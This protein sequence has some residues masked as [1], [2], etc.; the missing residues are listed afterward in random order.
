MTHTILSNSRELRNELIDQ[1]AQRRFEMHLRSGVWVMGLAAVLLMGSIWRLGSLH[2]QTNSVLLWLS[3]YALCVFTALVSREWLVRYVLRSQARDRWHI[4]LALLHGVMWA[5]VPILFFAAQEPRISMMMVCVAAG[6]CALAIPMCGTRPALYALFTLPILITQVIIFTAH[7]LANQDSFHIFLALLAFLI[8]GASQWF[9]RLTYRTLY[10]SIFLSYE[11]QELVMQLRDQAHELAI[12]TSSAQKANLAKTKFLAA[13]SHD[14]RQPVHAL[15]LFIEVLRTTPLDQRQQMIVGNIRAASQASREL[16]SSLLDYSQIE[17]GVMTAKPESC[18]L[19]AILMRLQEEFGPQADAKNLVYRCRDSEAIAHCDSHMV[20]LVLR[21][22]IS[23]AIRYTAQGGVLVAV[24]ARGNEWGVQVWDTGIG[25]AKHE[26]EDIFKEFHQVGNPERD[27]QK[28]V[29]LGLAIAQ[30]L[31]KTMGTRVSVRSVVGR[32][33]VFTLWLPKAQAPIAATH[34]SLLAATP[35]LEPRVFPNTSVLIVDDMASVRDG[36]K[37]LLEHWGCQVRTAQTAQQA[38]ALASEALPDILICDYRLQNN[39]TGV[40][41]VAAIKALA[42]LNS[43]L[44]TIMITGDIEPQR[45]E[46]ATSLGATLLYKPISITALNK[47]VHDLAQ[48][49]L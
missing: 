11:N 45:L 16:L 8:I 49:S 42:P 26:Q 1:E 32:G 30:G 40:Q 44:G 10:E 28:G 43:M 29:G 12:Q 2:T 27:Q 38:I 31:A 20:A 17:A 14:L 23:N 6:L 35:A 36:M 37:L 9:S 13:A 48:I 3:A 21:N 15:N 18:S 33:S 4:A 39:N 22:F 41:V 34:E 5:F 47:A 25:I 7:A 46:E 24:R 19:A